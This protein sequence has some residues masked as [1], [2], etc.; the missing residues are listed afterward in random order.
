M[1]FMKYVVYDP[2]IVFY[3]PVVILWK[4]WCISRTLF[5]ELISVLC[6]IIIK[7]YKLGSI[8]CEVVIVFFTS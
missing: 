4:S 1:Y 3:E 5:Y 8:Y 6:L 2:G 7:I